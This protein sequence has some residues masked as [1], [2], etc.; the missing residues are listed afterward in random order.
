MIILETEGKTGEEFIEQAIFG[1]V[2]SANLVEL[3][4]L[5]A[6]GFAGQDWMSTI[7]GGLTSQT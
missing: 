1:V 7:L 5:V 6:K 4:E 3:I 2:L